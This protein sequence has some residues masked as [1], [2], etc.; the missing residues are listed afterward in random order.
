MNPCNQI[1]KIKI[2][3]HF[4]SKVEQ[5]IILA[6][7]ECTVPFKMYELTESALEESYETKKRL[8]R[9]SYYNIGSKWNWMP[10]V[11]AIFLWCTVFIAYFKK[12]YK[13]Y[14]IK[15]ITWMIRNW[16]FLE[17]RIIACLVKQL[18]LSD[19]LTHTDTH[20]HRKES[21]KN[22]FWKL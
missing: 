1:S 9:F 5:R 14:C 12:Y 2:G 10:V 21:K 7:L 13:N 20:T 22:A 8:Y 19:T 15:I 4:L 6:I 3:A 17:S 16:I 18:S 11:L